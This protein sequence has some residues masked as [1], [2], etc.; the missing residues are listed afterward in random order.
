MDVRF[1]HKRTF[2][3]QLGVSAFDPKRTYVATSLLYH[4]GCTDRY[5]VIEICDVL[6]PH[7]ETAR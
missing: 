5:P 4:Y 1:G 3:L 6:V 2:A 7:P